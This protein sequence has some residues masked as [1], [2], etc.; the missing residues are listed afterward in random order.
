MTTFEA[1]GHTWDV[2][3]SSDEPHDGVSALIFRCATDSGRGWRVVEVPSAE[4]ASGRVDRLG[5]EEL[6]T[7]Y[8]RSQPFDYAH[9]P[10]AHENR[11]GH[12]S[13]GV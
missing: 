5:D 3:L 8:D 11:I 2:Y 1:D 13:G 6:R 10:K 12:D 9:D 7:L 4:F